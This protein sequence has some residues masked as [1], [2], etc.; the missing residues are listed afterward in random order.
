MGVAA[1]AAALL[2]YAITL[3][4]LV[5]RRL[6]LSIFLLAAY[7]LLQIVFAVRP[8]LAGATRQEDLQAPIRPF[9]RLAFTAA[10]VNLLVIALINPIRQDRVRDRFPPIEQDAIVIGLLAE[11]GTFVFKEQ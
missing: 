5:K 1:L 9:E 2:V 6:K 8:E 11:V 3:N 4:R 10:V 7:I